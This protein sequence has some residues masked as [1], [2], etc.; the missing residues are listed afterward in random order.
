MKCLFG[1]K[2]EG[3][4]TVIRSSK[5]S[6]ICCKSS[7][8]YHW[9]LHPDSEL[10]QRALN[11]SSHSSL[12]LSPVDFVFVLPVWSFTQGSPVP[13][14]SLSLLRSAQQAQHIHMSRGSLS[15]LLWHLWAA[16]LSL[17]LPFN[18]HSF[19]SV[20]VFAF[21]THAL[22]SSHSIL[23]EK[24]HNTGPKRVCQHRMKL[25]FFLLSLPL[26]PAFSEMKCH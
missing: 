20:S 11:F 19:S 6:L 12:L 25:I 22:T 4:Q 18:T 15:C 10:P 13:V 2:V 1:L 3:G 5:S 21:S 24:E 8:L 23:S 9:A 26:I 17:S 7:P 14:L 16:H